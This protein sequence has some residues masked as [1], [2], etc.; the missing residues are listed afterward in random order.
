MSFFAVLKRP[1]ILFV[2]IVPY[3]CLPGSKFRLLLCTELSLNIVLSYQRKEVGMNG[4]A[5][6]S[7]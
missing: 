3:Y 2:N 1:L 6:E 7:R 4:Y 5:G